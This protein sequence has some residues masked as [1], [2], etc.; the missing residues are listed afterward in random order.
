MT[1]GKKVL[2]LLLTLASTAVS[3][4][5]FKGIVTDKSNSQPLIGVAV[6]VDGTTRGT[7]TDAEGRFELPLEKGRYRIVVSYISYVTQQFDISRP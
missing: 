5:S 7:S 2:T 6:V 3:A 4:A 1:I